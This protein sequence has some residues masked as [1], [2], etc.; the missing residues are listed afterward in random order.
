MS[1]EPRKPRSEADAALEREIRDGRKFTLAEAIGRLAG[2]GMMKG[3][4]PATGK[5]QAAAQ[6]ENCLERHLPDSSGALAA[7]LL[8]QVRE[9]DILLSNLDQ[10]LVV[11]AAFV[12]RVLENDFA[13]QELVRESDVEWGRN[14]G[15]RP[16]F[17]KAGAPPHQ[18]D[19]Y[20][21]ES[22]RSNLSALLTALSN[23]PGDPGIAWRGPAL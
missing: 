6:I 13:L 20:T 15:E 17:Q 18:D 10:P 4:S 5:Q 1:D 3:V 19:P 23:A 7:V 22:V 12:Q 21:S 9:S 14:F 11:L 2:P 8:R 16:Y